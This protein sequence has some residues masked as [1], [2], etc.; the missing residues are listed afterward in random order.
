[1]ITGPI[2]RAARAI[3]EINRARLATAS[4]I[5]EDLIEA[6]ERKISTPADDAIHA[7]QSALEE[8]GA[9]FIPEKGADGAGVRLK[10]SRSVTKRLSTLESEGGPVASDDVP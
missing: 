3:V 1:M 4:G 8:L 10:F 6:F 5:G 9:V 2:C 7:L